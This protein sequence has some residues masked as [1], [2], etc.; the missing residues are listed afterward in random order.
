MAL[1][2][3]KSGLIKNVGWNFDESDALWRACRVAKRLPQIDLDCRP[4][5]DSLGELREGTA[6]LAAI[7]FLERPEPVFRRRMLAGNAHDRTSGE[8]CSAEA[9]DRVG[10]PAPGRDAADSGR[11]SGSRPRVR[12][13]GA[14]LLMPH[15][16]KF[17]AMIAQRS[18]NRPSM[19]AIDRKQ[20]FD[21]LRS[22]HARN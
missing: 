15:M 12:G 2:A 16:H 22:E 5:E 20:V 11:R 17:D 21:A 19:A 7:G 18:Q 1:I 6:D 14:G 8:T 13:V 9:G 10:Q 4:V 3:R